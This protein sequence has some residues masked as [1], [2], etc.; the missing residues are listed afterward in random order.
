MKHLPS[1]AGASWILIQ[2]LNIVLNMYVEAACFKPRL[3]N[4]LFGELTSGE[5]RG[6]KNIRKLI[7]VLSLSLSL[8]ST[9]N[10]IESCGY[11]K[12]D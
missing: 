4:A 5:S 6:R 1:A 8:S 11:I 2:I 10:V 3:M 9:P 12:E 7:V